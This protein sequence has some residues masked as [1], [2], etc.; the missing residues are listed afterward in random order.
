MRPID[1]RAVPSFVVSAL[2]GRSVVVHGDGL[3]TRSLCYV[4][5]TVRGLRAVLESTSPGPV[6]IGSPEEA[7]VLSV[8]ERIARIAGTG[9]PIRFGPRPVDDPSMRCP[10]IS[11]ALD[12]FGWAPEVN[13]DDGL[14]RTIAWFEDDG[15]TPRSSHS[16]VQ[17][18]WSA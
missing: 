6:N 5:D 16:A 1:G 10:D 3:Q 17:P 18:Q 8:A 13:L 4:D 15:G 9:V 12:L 14:Q 7:T 11:L 2:S